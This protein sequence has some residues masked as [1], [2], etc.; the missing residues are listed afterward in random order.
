MNLHTLKK[1][2]R[3]NKVKVTQTRKKHKFYDQHEEI[4]E[5]TTFEKITFTKVNI[6][7]KTA[8]GFVILNSFGTWIIKTI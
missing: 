1:F 5:I 4:N 7:N 2:V 6:I 8:N 3:N